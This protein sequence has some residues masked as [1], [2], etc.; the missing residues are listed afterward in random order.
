MP[1][2][3]DFWNMPRTVVF[4][5]MAPDAFVLIDDDGAVRIAVDGVRGAAR[6][7]GGIA[8]MEA[9]FLEEIP[10][11]F[12]LVVHALFHLDERVDARAEIFMRL[13]LPFERGVHIRRQVVPLFTRD[14]A[15]ATR[16]TT[17]HVMQHCDFLCHDVRSSPSLYGIESSILILGSPFYEGPFPRR[18]GRDVRSPSPADR[19]SRRR[20]PQRGRGTS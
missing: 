4:A 19:Y 14:H 8:A 15:A 5:V 20:C 1:H 9:I 12:P 3:V 16:G 7:A 18:G 6:G 2:L 10:V 11:E 13:V 17:R